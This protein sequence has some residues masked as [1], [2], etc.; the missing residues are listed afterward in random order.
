MFVKYERTGSVNDVYGGNVGPPHASITVDSIQAVEQTIQTQPLSSF[1]DI[2][3]EC[4]LRKS[5]KRKSLK[6]CLKLFQYK[7]QALEH[8]NFCTANKKQIF[9]NDFLK[10]IDGREIAV[11]S[12][13]FSVETNFYLDGF[14]NRQNCRFWG[15]E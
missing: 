14:V 8:R 13:C 5:S 15:M 11:G 9:T 1:M 7:I 12:I 4:G 6:K 3:W 2:A 10:N